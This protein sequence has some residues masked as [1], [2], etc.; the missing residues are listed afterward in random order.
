MLFDEPV[1]SLYHRSVNNQQL[2]V[3]FSNSSIA[4]AIDNF[5]FRQLVKMLR[6]SDA[7][8]WL[9]V[10]CSQ[11]LTGSKLPSQREVLAVFMHHHKICKKTTKESA[12]LVVEKII[13]F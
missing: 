12:A 11:E 4:I 5:A 3:P 8:I 9:V 2:A 6:R 1:Q 7:D 10:P 13:L